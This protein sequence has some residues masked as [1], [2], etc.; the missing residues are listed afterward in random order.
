MNKQ[1]ITSQSSPPCF[2]R[3]TTA[4]LATILRVEPQTIRAGLCRNGNYLGLRPVVKL[5][6]GRWLWDALSAQSIVGGEVQ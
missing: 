2:S 6:N 5:P 4:Q 1:F 3:L